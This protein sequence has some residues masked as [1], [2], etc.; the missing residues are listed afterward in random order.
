MGIL[1]KDTGYKLGKITQTLGKAFVGGGGLDS[2]GAGATSAGA[3]SAA[4]GAGQSLL[5]KGFSKAVGFGKSA[6]GVGGA[7]AG[8]F[9]FKDALSAVSPKFAKGMY[10]SSAADFRETQGALNIAK[11]DQLR[12][13]QE[14][15]D[16]GGL[17]PG[18]E[19]KAKSMAID[20]LKNQGLGKNDENGNF[21]VQRSRLQEAMKDFQNDPAR[22]KTL[23]TEQKNSLQTKLDNL[24]VA[25]DQAKKDLALKG[26]KDAGID[27]K[28]LK[29]RG[30]NLESLMKEEMAKI[31]SGAIPFPEKQGIEQE[32]QLL[33]KQIGGV[34]SR[35]E[36]IES[37]ITTP[38]DAAKT[39]KFKMET[40]ILGEPGGGAKQPTDIRSFET[41][42]GIDPKLRGTQEYETARLRYRELFEG[43]QQVVGSTPSGDLL[44]FN[45]I[46]GKIDV[47]D[48]PTEILPKTKK[49]I[50]EEGATRLAGMD[51]LINQIQDIRNIAT[52]HPEF[53]GPVEGKWNQ[54]QSRFANNGDFTELDRSISSLITIAYE[55]SGKQISP[56][57]ME[58][59][60]GAILPQVT[61]PDDNFL[62]S[63]DFAEKWITGKRDNMESRFKQSNIFVGERSDRSSF[64][65]N[66]RT[67]EERNIGVGGNTDATTPGVVEGGSADLNRVIKRFGGIQ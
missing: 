22:Q 63:L 54:L 32:A 16:T 6:M 27:I 17:F 45:N 29:K 34:A 28:S 20:Y 5:S 30:V 26:L 33:Q 62:V 18:L 19:P 40:R 11:L 59:L 57:E 39:E 55:L 43:R 1:G 10:M 21:V 25:K 50:T 31:D 7:N 52:E 4:S 66:N 51:G 37:T 53:I 41:T 13:D 46:T 58:M 38:L 24:G 48:V 49:L 60:K 35:L 64:T 44:T 47:K 42:S 23:M 8:G 65:V 36:D 15:V 12:Q 3:S 2:I 9:D 67:D 14:L 61:Q 56:Q